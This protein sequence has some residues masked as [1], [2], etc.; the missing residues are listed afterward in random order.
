MTNSELLNTADLLRLL[1]EN[2]D[3]AQA[4][5]HG[6]HAINNPSLVMQLLLHQKE[7]GLSIAQIADTAMLSQSFAYQIFGGIRNPGRNTVICI[8][9]VM[10]LSLDSVQRL[11]TLSQKGELYPRVRR[12]AAIIFA[13]EHNY[14]LIQMED[15]LQKAG[16]ASILPRQT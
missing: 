6:E 16:E 8:A 3:F 5:E 1:R 12:D 15:L 7:S 9:C 2:G 4:L 10:H 14:S 11:L 13:I